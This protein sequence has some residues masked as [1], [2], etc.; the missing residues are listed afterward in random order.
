[1]LLWHTYRACNA[2]F[3][4]QCPLAEIP[5]LPVRV[6]H[7]MHRWTM[8]RYLRFKQLILLSMWTPHYAH[9]PH[10]PRPI[11]L[12]HITSDSR[13][14]LSVPAAR[15][16]KRLWCKMT[17]TRSPKDAQCHDRAESDR[18]SSAVE[19]RETGSQVRYSN[20]TAL[21]ELDIQ[22]SIRREC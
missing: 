17:V 4:S 14:Q 19:C 1:M 5:V 18:I 10:I 15:F 6:M 12:H 7:W 9:F 2:G 3:C 13:R 20:G 22:Q 21:S 8:I 16:S 11:C